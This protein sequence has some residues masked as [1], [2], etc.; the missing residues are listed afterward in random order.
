MLEAPRESGTFYGEPFA[1]P[2]QGF[3]LFARERDFY[4]ECRELLGAVLAQ[5]APDA[6][7][8]LFAVAVE[9]SPPYTDA[10][11]CVFPAGPDPEDFRPLLDALRVQADGVDCGPAHALDSAFYATLGTFHVRFTDPPEQLVLGALAG[12]GRFFSRAAALQLERYDD[13]EGGERPPLEAVFKGALVAQVL[14]ESIPAEEHAG[15]PAV[16]V[17]RVPL[18]THAL[19]VVLERA[20]DALQDYVST[21]E[22]DL[23]PPPGDVLREAGRRLAES[24]IPVKGGFGGAAFF[25]ACTTISSLRYEGQDAHGELALAVPGEAPELALAF[26]APPVLT[27]VRAVRK[28]LQ[29]CGGP[30]CLLTDSERILGLARRDLALVPGARCVVFERHHSWELRLDGTLLMVVRYG[31]PLLPR[32]RIDREHFH[33]RFAEL[34]GHR[35]GSDPDA[36]W[37]IVEAATHREHGA[38]IVVSADAA[39]EARRLGAGSTRVRPRRLPLDLVFPVTSIDGA[40]M[41]SPDGVC[42]AI[43][44]ILDGTASPRGTGQRGAR[45]NSSLRYVD[46]HPGTMAVVVSEDGDV[47]LVVPEGQTMG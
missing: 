43:G 15:V 36:V 29:M 44:V 45:F 38:L 6:E 9:M 18:L 35:A 2:M 14:G 37:A 25:D 4:A 3:T 28:I 39:G 41:L 1:A 26:S 16:P 10:V 7:V 46:S 33:L 19:D 47:E 42:H 22:S 27:Q 21:A 5:V 30:Y 12:D 24:L 32:A 17:D 23:L 11:P 20:C 34:F 13:S 8:R 40:V 31:E